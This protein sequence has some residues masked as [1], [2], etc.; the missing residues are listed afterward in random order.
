M[1]EIASHGYVKGVRSL[2]ERIVKSFGSS[3][4]RPPVGHYNYEGMKRI[5][6]NP[7]TSFQSHASSDFDGRLG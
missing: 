2:D 7:A 1:M 5:G 3:G 4:Y 6:L